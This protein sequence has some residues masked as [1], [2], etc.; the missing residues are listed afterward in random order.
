MFEF[1]HTV[2]IMAGIGAFENS[3]TAVSAIGSKALIVCDSF[4]ISSGLAKRLAELLSTAG[5]RSAVF[6][7]VIPNPTT[8]I[9]DAGGGAARKEKCDVIIGIGGGSSMDT[10][11][12]IAVAASHDG[13]IWAY[14]IG[15]KHAT[16]ATLPIVAITTTSGTGSQCTPFAVIINPDTN[17]KPGFGGPCLFPKIAIVDAQLTSSMPPILTAVTGADVFTHAVEAYTSKWSS[18]IVDMYAQKAIELV[19]KNL[20]VAYADGSNLQARQ[21]MA[22]ADTFAGVAIS[23]G[24]VSV[25]HV[26]SHVIG[27]HYHYIAHGD[28]LNTIYPAILSINKKVCQKNT[29]GSPKPSAVEKYRMLLRHIRNFSGNFIFQTA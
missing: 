8:D 1:N 3:G 7:K 20:P 4:V 17:Q 22:I 28:V 14:A 26:I 16:G 24:G 12:A 9:V 5:V 11:K 29:S 27:G 10:A 25:A 23:H 18:P 13:P 15:E 2:K 21:A 6:D 19:V